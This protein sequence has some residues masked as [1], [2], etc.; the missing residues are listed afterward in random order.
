MK[1]IL[2]R[3]WG[4]GAWLLIGQV[5]LADAV[6]TSD[7]SKIVGRIERMGG[8]KLIILTEIAGRL[9]LDA[10]KITAVAVDRKV[11]VEF[12][13]GDRLVGT[14]EV[15]ED[16]STSIMQGPLGELS[17]LPGQIA[18]IWPVGGEDPQIQAITA[19]AERQ[20]KGLIPVWTVTLEAGGSRREGNTDTLEAR[21]RLDLTRK[22]DRKL[23]NFF[24][25]AKYDE[26]DDQ[27]T[28][29]EYRGGLRFE[30][31]IDENWLWYTRVELEF[32]EFEDLD[33]RATVAAGGG[34]YWLKKPDHELKGLFGIGYRHESY[35]GDRTEDGAVFDLGLAYRINVA[36][37]VQFT[38][39]TTFS[40]DIQE[41]DNYRLDV[42]T[43]LVFPL[44]GQRVKLK[45]G[46]TNEYNSRPQPGL[47]RLDNTFYANLVLSLK[48]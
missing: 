9:E 5:S 23:V 24:L 34:Y 39:T 41:L 15:S 19:E 3:V 33:L 46:M 13:S 48:R 11:T 40:P 37:W 16:Q 28:V 31:I 20:R 1:R 35:D 7:G 27:R 32:D 45:V 25:A 47:D 2:C 26:Q 8:G 30:N 4:I 18:A 17:I 29:N 12:T 6:F 21:G 43:A 36:P 10:S 22:T 14:I 38:H 42:D 44:K